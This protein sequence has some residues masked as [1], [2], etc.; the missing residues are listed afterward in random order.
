MLLG[1]RNLVSGDTRRVTVDYS[2][3]LTQGVKLDV[4]TLTLTGAATSSAQL[5]VVLPANTAVYFMV[6][7][8]DVG[9]QFSVNLQVVDTDG[10]VFNDVVEYTVIAS[11]A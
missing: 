8:G 6:T 9:E 5:P 2:G 4:A 1:Q 7:G 11:N 3:V 10:E